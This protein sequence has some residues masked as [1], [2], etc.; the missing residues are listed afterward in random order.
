MNGQLKASS[1][2]DLAER[3]LPDV[4]ENSPTQNPRR[5]VS[6][7]KT[8][9]LPR[10]M[11]RTQ[12]SLDG[13]LM[14][15]E[16]IAKLRRWILSLVTGEWVLGVGQPSMTEGVWFAVNFDLEV[17]PKITSIYP[18]LRLTHA[19][20]QNVS[21]GRICVPLRHSLNWRTFTLQRVFLISGL[22]SF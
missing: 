22:G 11:H 4:S 5:R 13:L 17:G 15:T 3:L 19:E 21:V 9:R 8:L 6:R 10:R 18:P 20:A 12:L 2:P 16:K 7:S 1:S 14:G